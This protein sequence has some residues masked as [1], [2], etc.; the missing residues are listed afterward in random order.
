MAPDNNDWVG[1]SEEH[2]FIIYDEF[3]QRTMRNFSWESLN[4]IM[5]GN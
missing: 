5:D 2:E 1:Y 4:K 3:E